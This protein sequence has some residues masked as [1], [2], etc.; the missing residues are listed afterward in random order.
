MLVISIVMV[1][2]SNSVIITVSCIAIRIVSIRIVMIL[3][4]LI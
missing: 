3:L 2:A 1:I 4:L